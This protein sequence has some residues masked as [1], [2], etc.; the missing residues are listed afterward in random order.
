MNKFLLWLKDSL[1][2]N[3]GK[4]SAKMLTLV[5]I[6]ILAST[7]DIIFIIISFRIVEQNAPT[8]S[9]LAVLDRLRDLI[10]LHFIVMLILFG[11]ATIASLVQLF[12]VIR[13]QPIIEDP[14]LTETVTKQSKTVTEIKP[15][16]TNTNEEVI[17]SDDSPA[18]DS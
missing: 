14:I 3:D 8:A 18:I 12:K 4:S 6:V 10:G 13:G 16:I 5:W 1:E 7:L 9:S 2:G 15:K 17:K 11:V